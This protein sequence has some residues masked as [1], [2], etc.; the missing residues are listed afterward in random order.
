V[1]WLIVLV[2]ACSGGAPGR[3][4]DVD[5][6]MNLVHDLAGSPRP[7]GSA[8]AAAAASRIE[9]ELQAAG[10]TVERFP[11]GAVEVPAIELAGTRMRAAH[12]AETRDPD[13]LVR[14]GPPGKALV[15]LAHYDTVPPSPGAVD[16]AA[17]VAILVELAVALR[18]HPPAQPVVLA[19]TAAEELGLVGAEALAERRGE[20][21]AFAIALDL[22][23]GSGRLTLN[24]ASELIG[25]S[26]LRWLAAAADRAGLVLSAPLPHRVISRW[27]PQA[28]RADHG[29]FTRRGIRAIHLY[30]R[31]Q[32][33]EWIDRAYHSARDVPARVSAQALDETGRL[34]RALVAEAP[35]PHAAD[36]FW[37]PLAHNT[38][39]PRWWLVALELLLAA[40]AL[41]ALFASPEGLV[42]VISRA[43]GG[44]R[45]RARGAGL[46]VALACHLVA[47][48]LAIALERL[49]ARGHPAAWI[50]APARALVG[51][52]LVI[53]GLLGLSTRAVGRVTTWAGTMRYLT[54]AVLACLV[55]GLAWLAAGGA[56]LAWIWLVPAAA[57]ALAPWLGR[58]APLALATAALPA[59]LVLAPLQLREAAWNGFLPLQIPL[60]AWLGV[61][62]LP[63][64]AAVAWAWRRRGP[65]SPLGTLLLAVGCGLAILAGAVLVSARTPTCTPSEFIQFHLACEPLGRA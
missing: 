61:V 8:S 5:R 7:E 23:G 31:G 4:I 28:E 44:G 65:T 43:R 18:D 25:A 16:N 52:A 39:V 24:G 57:L 27:W 45:E 15:I 47:V 53:A 64:P 11:V 48:G 58:A 10:L 59:L 21:V 19:F 56:E 13:L 49:A 40:I 46:V 30:N 55:P 54:T 38:V 6:A 9:H 36:G 37:L 34:L 62:G 32:D 3:G 12:R 20:Q 33:G 1:R 29:A 26:E 35:P 60:A 51:E 17:A 14:L 2:V 50:H 63:L 41:V 42:A 22:I